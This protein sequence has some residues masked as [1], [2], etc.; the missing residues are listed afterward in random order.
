LLIKKF[1]K[2]RQGSSRLVFRILPGIVLLL[3]LLSAYSGNRA[4]LPSG[5]KWEVLGQGLAVTNVPGPHISKYADSRV[6]VVKIDPAF[7][8]FDLAVSS[9]SDSLQRTIKEWCELENFDGAINAG[10]YSLIDHV[11][12]VGY[13]QHYSHINNPVIKENFNA[14]V[15]FNTSDSLLPPFQIVDMVNQDWKTIVPKY[16][17]CF[18][19]I[20]MIDNNT[21]PVYWKPK[22][23]QRCSM[24]LLATDK[25][26]N[27]LFLFARSP[28]TANEM[29]KFML[30]AGLDIRT[31]MYLEGGPE[32]SMYVKSPGNEMIK[33][34]S[35]V[36]YSNPNDDNLELRKMPNV[37]GFKRK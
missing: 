34:G 29:T 9:E 14:M 12:G 1:M 11:S 19:S 31:A 37:L 17:C 22:R 30:A 3:M 18:Q 4:V 13:M 35:F 26:G 32:A 10:M 28:Y 24:T 6:T 21:I 25:S 27:V 15:V 8:T 20:R 16:H 5:I 36:S 33:F 7:Y 2:Q 23:V